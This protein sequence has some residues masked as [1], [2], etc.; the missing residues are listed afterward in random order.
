VSNLLATPRIYLFYFSRPNSESSGPSPFTSDV[1][2]MLLAVHQTPAL[3]FPQGGARQWGLYKVAQKHVIPA[4]SDVVSSNS[5]RL[6]M[7]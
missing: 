6:S 4:R 2:A 5:K 3:S 7:M 1:D